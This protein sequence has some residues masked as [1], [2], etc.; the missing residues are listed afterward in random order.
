[1]SGWLAACLACRVACVKRSFLTSVS[2]FWRVCVRALPPNT[3]VHTSIRRHEYGPDLLSKITDYT[4]QAEV[5]GRSARREQVAEEVGGMS[6]MQ[7]HE[8]CEQYPQLRKHALPSNRCE[9][10]LVLRHFH[11]KYDQFAKTTGSGHT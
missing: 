10:R 9:K 5:F 2:L 7:L 11:T 6:D 4:W 3:C 8:L 1:V